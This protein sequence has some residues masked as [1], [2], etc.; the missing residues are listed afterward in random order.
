M[1]IIKCLKQNLR[2]KNVVK[3]DEQEMSHQANLFRH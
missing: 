1:R 3:I 2:Q